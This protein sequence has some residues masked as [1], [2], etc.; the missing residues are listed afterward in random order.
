MFKRTITGIVVAAFLM[1]SSASTAMGCAIGPLP[2]WYAE[3]PK[4]VHN[5]LSSVLGISFPKGTL[6]T[7]ENKGLTSNVYIASPDTDGVYPGYRHGRED[8]R[9]LDY[10]L[11]GDFDPDV[12]ISVGKGLS[13]G[14]YSFNGG[15]SKTTIGDSNAKMGTVGLAKALGSS[16]NYESK[17][18]RNRSRPVN[19]SV[20]SPDNQTMYAFYE[21]KRYDIKVT[22]SYSLNPDY[23]ED[24][25]DF[26]CG[27]TRTKK[28]TEPTSIGKELAEIQKTFEKPSGTSDESS[29]AGYRLTAMVVV[30]VAS[31]A[32]A[33]VLVK[34]MPR[35][36]LGKGRRKKRSKTLFTIPIID[37]K[38]KDV[39]PVGRTAILAILLTLLLVILWLTQTDIVM[40]P[41]EL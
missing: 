25:K 29:A 12:Q 5:P 14:V 17:Q 30:G 3:H 16:D 35:T 27:P 34:K 10:I 21:G 26:G 18:V 20:P 15:W 31:L 24:K 33:Y 4:L 1:S 9:P 28:D 6:V 8:Y 22:I 32:F 36:M 7:F 38:V 23:E 19:T 39:G 13:A 37:L 41:Y 40:T 2:A 11:G